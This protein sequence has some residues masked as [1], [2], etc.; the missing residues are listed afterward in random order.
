MN[1]G[2][3]AASMVVGLAA[4]GSG[5]GIMIAGMATVGAWKKC[6]I[7]KKAAPMT[8][9][10]FGHSLNLVL[11]VLSVLVHGVRLN[12]LEFSS[13][14]GLAWSGFAFK[15]FKEIENK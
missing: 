11:A 5:I 13:H 9:L 2:L 8:F 4:I 7:N 14:V 6:Y 10:A 12:I 3:L 15:P 1:L